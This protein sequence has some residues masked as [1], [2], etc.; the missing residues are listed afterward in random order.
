MNI[1]AETIEDLLEILAGLKLKP[2]IKIESNDATIMHSIARQ[3]FR[4]T[5]LTDRQF[6]LMQ[7]KLLHY[8]KDFMELGYNFDLALEKL[9]QPLRQIDRSKFIKL[10]KTSD[11]Y[12]DK[13]YESYKSD[14]AWVQVRFPFSKALIMKINSIRAVRDYIHHKGE[15]SHYFK[16]N[17]KNVKS[18]IEAFSNSNFEIEKDILDYYEK[19]KIIENLKEEYIPLIKNH[20][21][22]NVNQNAKKLIANEIGEISKNNILQLIDRRN[23]YGITNFTYTN[24]KGTLQETIAL[25]ENRD[26]LFRPNEYKLND[27]LYAL[28]DLNRYPLLFVLDEIH[29]E[30]QLH[31]TFNFY[32]DFIP[33]EQQSAIF[34]LEGTDQEFNQ[35]VKDYK[36]NNWVDSSTKIVYT[37]VNKIPKVLFKADWKPIATVSFNSKTNRNLDLYIKTYCD[38]IIFY[39]NEISPLRRYSSYYV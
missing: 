27:V 37:S 15:H 11:V 12:Q 34:R 38:L 6:N 4:G 35:M 3:T 5:A 9:R 1:I 8:R 22:V 31:Q 24:Q 29:A 23:R 36:I 18:I 19:I 10:V 32:K 16:F 14:W 33:A 21:L 20:Q 39:D 25:R 26:V 30:K 7:E 13:V 28:N 2:E 17:E